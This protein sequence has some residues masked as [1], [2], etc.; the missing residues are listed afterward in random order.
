[1]SDEALAELLQWQQQQHQR[2][3]D[4]A[5]AQGRR[6][7][8]TESEMLE[9]LPGMKPWKERLTAELRHIEAP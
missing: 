8:A 6:L 7:W 2:E 9:A 5:L 3:I 1:M 4:E